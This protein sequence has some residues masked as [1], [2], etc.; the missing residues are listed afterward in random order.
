MFFL[1]Q[2]FQRFCSFLFLKKNQKKKITF[3][4]LH[5]FRIQQFDKQNI[6]DTSEAFEE[7]Q[8]FWEQ[9]D[10]GKQWT[11]TR[12]WLLVTPVLLYLMATNSTDFRRQPLLLNLLA[13]LVLVIPKL[14]N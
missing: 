3:P 6:Y 5:W 12:K 7:P 11:M 9:I 10:D 1:F 8:T 4:L 2:N 14:K 13:M